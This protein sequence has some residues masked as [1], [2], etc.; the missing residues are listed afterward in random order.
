MQILNPQTWGTSRD[1]EFSH[2]LLGDAMLLTKPSDFEKQGS[3]QV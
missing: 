2:K 1:S 3:G